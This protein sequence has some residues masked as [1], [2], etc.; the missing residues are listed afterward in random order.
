[1][2]KIEKEETANELVRVKLQ[3]VLVALTMNK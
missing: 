2:S 3:Y 1:M